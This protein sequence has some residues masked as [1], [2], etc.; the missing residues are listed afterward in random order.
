MKIPWTRLE[1]VESILAV[2][3]SDCKI[4]YAWY[5]TSRSISLFVKEIFKTPNPLNL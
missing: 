5:F 1:Y 3:L 2:P 4:P